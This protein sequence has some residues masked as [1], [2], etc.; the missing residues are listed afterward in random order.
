[1]FCEQVWSRIQPLLKETL[2]HPF[3][4]EL[5]AGTLDQD[6]FRFYLVQDARYLADFAKALAHAAAIAPAPDDA[7]FL[8]GSSANVIVV[9][10]GLHERY[11]ARYGLTGLD[12][13]PTSPSATAYN[14]HLLAA[15]ARGGF[16]PLMATVLPCFWIYEYVGNAIHTE[17]TGAANPYADWIETY[18]DPGFAESV[19]RAK[20]ITDRAAA[21][22]SPAE[23]RR[24]VDAFVRSSEYEWLFWDSA[25]RRERWPTVSLT[26]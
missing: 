3:N 14:N 16:G 4:R 21:T 11:F 7:A 20:D 15:V 24:M 12:D 10:R 8:A 1:M 19:A 2:N 23:R 25:Y 17:Q 5:S 13:I 18:A 22:A 6:V 9:E 26:A